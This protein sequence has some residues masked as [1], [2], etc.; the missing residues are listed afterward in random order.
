MGYSDVRMEIE[1][2]MQGT[3]EMVLYGDVWSLPYPDYVSGPD[4]I[5]VFPKDGAVC[6]F[7][8]GTTVAITGPPPGFPVVRILDVTTSLIGD[9]SGGVG[10]DPVEGFDIFLLSGF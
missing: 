9:C 2:E 8:R 6:C 3:V 1:V 5:S 7:P 4:W 10:F